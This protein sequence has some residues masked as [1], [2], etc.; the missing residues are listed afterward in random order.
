MVFNKDSINLKTKNTFV[1]KGGTWPGPAKAFIDSVLPFMKMYHDSGT[2]QALRNQAIT[3]LAS[4]LGGFANQAFFDAI[5]TN[6]VVFMADVL[7]S[8]LLIR[9]PPPDTTE[10][11]VEELIP[12]D[13]KDEFEKEQQEKKEREAEAEKERIEEEEEK[14]ELAAKLQACQ[15]RFQDEIKAGVDPELAQLRKDACFSR[16]QGNDIDDP[17]IIINERE[18]EPDPDPEK[19]EDWT[20]LSVIKKGID[21]VVPDASRKIPGYKT[22][23]HKLAKKIQ[24]AIVEINPKTLDDLKKVI[25]DLVSVI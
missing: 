18:D 22:A 2:N 10:E 3:A 19:T 7:V 1:A 13:V 11:E 12:D 14:E 15:I 17:P 5:T 23:R 24:S 21:K 6:N 8:M 25:K 4:F 9:Y 20:S 16:A